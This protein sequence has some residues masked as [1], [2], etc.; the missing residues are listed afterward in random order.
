MGGNVKVSGYVRHH[1][2]GIP[3]AS[4]FIEFGATEFPGSDT[5]L[6]DA[7]TSA[8]TAAYYEFTGL[9]AGDYY[10]YS[11]GFDS[12]ISLPVKGGIPLEICEGAETVGT[13]IPV[14]ED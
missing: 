8:N 10:L 14:T 1:N 9:K 13:N 2:A 11:V 3:R 7:R 6:Y 5:A 12:A 4:V